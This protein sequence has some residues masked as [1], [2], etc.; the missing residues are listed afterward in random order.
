MI[1]LWL[2]IRK[3]QQ[4]S[5]NDPFFVDENNKRITKKDITAAV[6]KVALACKVPDV[7]IISGR[8]LRSGGATWLALRGIN[9]STIK[10]IGNWK[11]DAIMHYLAALPSHNS[12]ISQQA[13]L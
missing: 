6:R 2:K 3:L 13:M 10:A 7:K 9:H 12:S 11:S 5:P 4:A 1:S 8:S